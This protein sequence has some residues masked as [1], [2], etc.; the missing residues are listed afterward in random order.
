VLAR[1]G[2]VV[3]RLR[4]LHEPATLPGVVETLDELLLVLP[5]AT[6]L[7]FDPGL[8]FHLYG[9]DVCLQAARSGR[10]SWP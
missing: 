8:G 3:D 10:R 4:L 6:P 1:A 9:A 7:G 2:R 5:R